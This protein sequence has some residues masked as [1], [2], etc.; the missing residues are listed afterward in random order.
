MYNFARCVSVAAVLTLAASPV[1][2]SELFFL[3]DPTLPGL[4][5]EVEFTLLNSTT[6]QVRMRNT[7]TG[8]PSGFD[9]SDQLLTGVSWD[10]GDPGFNGDAMI[11]GGSVAIGP[12]S[13]SVNFDTGSYGP[14]SDVGGEYGYGNTDGTGALT[15]FV[16]ANTSQA[17]PFGG[18]NLDGPVEIDGPQAGLVADP[19]LVDVGGLGAI[20][21][22]II[23][24]L[25]LSEAI[26][27]LDFLHD[28]LV[29]VEFGSDAGFIDTPEPGSLALL[30]VGGLAAYRRRR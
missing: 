21:N 28:N 20:Q 14:G 29:R 17:T 18:A 15:N 2:A 6:L 24:T 7:S 3:S 9:S 13:S 16:S 11:T 5:A 27:N 22:E 25:T 26:S 4:S 19:I 30:L 8:V 23:A 12:S 1:Y 10:F